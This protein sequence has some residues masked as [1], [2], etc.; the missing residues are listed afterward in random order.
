MMMIKKSARAWVSAFYLAAAACTKAGPTSPSQTS[1]PPS[2]V[3]PAPPVAAVAPAATYTTTTL[4]F[5]SD[6]RHYVGEGRSLTLTKQ[7]ARFFAQIANQG[8]WLYV[9]IRENPGPV[10]W[11]FHIASPGPGGSLIVPGVYN[12]SRD[13]LSGA[14][15]FTFFG[16]GNG[17]NQETNRLVVHEFEFD[18]VSNT[19]RNF[20]ASFE[21]HCE[22]A[23]P[24]I[25]G[26]IAILA[27][28][29]S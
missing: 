29:Q 8:G 17:C 23:S 26:E 9:E 6:E 13:P 14:W 24:A 21:G 22:G 19:L 27:D 1:A 2:A 25:R 20:R 3:A 28:W 18:R 10:A 7:N 15:Y 4:S 5:T 11:G 12:A 16:N